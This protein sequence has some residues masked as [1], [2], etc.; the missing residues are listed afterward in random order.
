MNDSKINQLSDKER[1][2]LERRI[3]GAGVKNTLINNMKITKGEK[4]G[5]APLSFAQEGLW[6]MDQISPNNTAYNLPFFIHISGPLKVKELQESLKEIVRRHESLRTTISNH[7]YENPI[8]NVSIDCDAMIEFI[9]LSYLPQIERKI[10]ADQIAEEEANRPF[11]LAKGPLFRAKLLRLEKEEH[12]LLTIMHHIISDALSEGILFRELLTHYKTL[13]SGELLYREDL[14]IQ[15]TDYAKWQRNWLNEEKLETL[16][17][18]WEKKLKDVPTLLRLPSARSHPKIR[19]NKGKIYYFELNESLT[20]SIK[21][22]GRQEG[23]TLF[24]FLLASFKTLLYRYTE[25]EEIVVGTSVSNRNRAEIEDVIGYFVNV[26]PLFSQ[27]KGHLSFRDLLRDIKDTTLGAF[28]H[29]ELP[30]GKLV[31]LIK[32]ER[33]SAYHPLVQT[34][35]VLHNS[36]IVDY[37]LDN[38]TFKLMD[39]YKTA[40]RFDLSLSAWET[41][42]SLTC[43]FEYNTDLFNEE[44]IVRMAGH[45]KNLLEEIITSPT[46]AIDGLSMLPSLEREKLLIEWNQT[47]QDFKV[48]ICPHHLFEEQAQK[49]P[50][51]IAIVSKYNQLTFSELNRRA[52]QLAH[53]LRSIGIKPEVPVGICME[54]SIEMVVAMLGILKAGG[55]YVPFETTNPADR[56]RYLIKDAEISVLLTQTNMVD[57]EVCDGISMICLDVDTFTE[58]S[59]ENLSCISDSSH[60]AYIIYTSGSTGMPKGVVVEHRQVLN[61][62][63]AMANVYGLEEDIQYA[64]V[65]PLSVDSSVLV[66]YGALCL[67]G[68]LHIISREDCLQPDNLATYF[69]ENKI[70]FL[71]IAPSHMAALLRAFPSGKVIPRRWLVM[72]GEALRWD[73]VKTIHALSEKCDVY[74]HYGP[75]ETTVGVLTGKVER[76]T[77]NDSATVPLGRPIG[78]ITVYILDSNMQPVPVGMTGHLY[79]GGK[80]VA[81]GYHN[82]SDLTKE[83]FI[84]DPFSNQPGARLYKSGDQARYLEDGRIEFIGREDDQVK[85]RGF[86]IELGE[87]MAIIA[88]HPLVQDTYVLVQGDVS[89]NK[90]LIGY[91][92]P[93]TG[94]EMLE[95]EELTNYL[96]QRLPAHMVPSTFIFMECLPRSQHG[97]LN[98]KELPIPDYRGDAKKS[99]NTSRKFIE[100]TIV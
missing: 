81:R 18:Y 57:G 27:V 50:D 3:R 64:M 35:F 41:P 74:N 63:W 53:H 48:D 32:P 11:D 75:T 92:V 9:D 77:V 28:D 52:N 36:P 40:S 100:T 71:K 73:L 82:R 23:V 25:Q 56:L 2:H 14:P 55:I 15:Y 8:Q 91:V 65:Q 76:E 95:E 54:Q 1:A 68:T 90:R 43:A 5:S 22:L 79:I 84:V 72:G 47:E 66:V 21:E 26:L 99:D 17:A 46:R 24:M 86:R 98:R 89:D 85:I 87:I 70:D 37:Q 60:G 19:S 67:G 7:Q 38:L 29:S 42:D 33:N 6:L 20:K 83:R 80:N 97:K 62:M 58:E 69:T 78:N 39:T 49:T 16:N 30:F 88:S 13:A 45:W 12:I 59:E 34:L 61:Y 93:V 51:K 10:R 31:E 44:I 94:H 4:K 96:K